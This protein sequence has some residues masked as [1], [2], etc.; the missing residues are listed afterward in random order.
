MEQFQWKSNRKAPTLADTPL[1]EQL[2]SS[3][4]LRSSAAHT[5]VA[6]SAHAF[7]GTY[8]TVLLVSILDMCGFDP[9]L[10]W[11]PFRAQSDDNDFDRTSRQLERSMLMMLHSWTP[12]QRD[13][14]FSRLPPE[15]IH[16]VERMVTV[17]S[18]SRNPFAQLPRMLRL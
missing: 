4:N 10:R 3:G 12:E 15:T 9:L 2:V 17:A 7:L 14:F 5:C 16:G 13:K 6:Q 18:G 1:L 8:M 11:S